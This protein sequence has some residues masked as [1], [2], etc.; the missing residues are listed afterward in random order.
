MIKN[1]K[2]ES[3]MKKLLFLFVAVFLL[4]SGCGNDLEYEIWKDTVEAFGNGNYQILHG[5][6][7]D[8]KIN[9]LYNCKHK[10]EVVTN[11]D[12]YVKS[13][14]YVFFA[15][16]FHRQKVY[17]KLNVETN[18]LLYYA[19]ENGDEYIAIEFVSEIEDNQIKLLSSFDDFS[20]E[21]KEIFNSL[22]NQLN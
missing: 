19:E 13:E 16:H 11:I 7:N 18:L 8:E 14:N 17:C 20:K 2:G 9:T 6:R 12:N 21:D 1:I 10:Q 15:G 22:M 4:L 3:Y 5:Y